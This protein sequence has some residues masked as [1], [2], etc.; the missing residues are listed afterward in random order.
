MNVFEIRMLHS[1]I[2]Y[3]IFF[4]LYCA[5]LILSFFFPFSFFF[6][7]AETQTV[8]LMV[9]GATQLTTTRNG[10]TARFQSAVGLSSNTVEGVSVLNF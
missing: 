3:I 9:R 8:M 1:E 6:R 5:A 4:A 7:A 10:I 2:I